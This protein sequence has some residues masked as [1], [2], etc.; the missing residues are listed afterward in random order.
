MEQRRR[1]HREFEE[2]Y[3]KYGTRLRF[4]VYLSKELTEAPLEDLE[5]SVRSYNCLKRA[6][7]QTVGDVVE[8]INGRTDLLKIRNLGMRSADEIMEAIMVYQYSL[9]SDE[10]KVR[11]LKRVAE[12][13]RNST[14]GHA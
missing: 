6:G 2:L 10:R 5:L 12:L 8:R 11:Y 4:S 1:T 13:N 7:M 9:L 14:A 3:E